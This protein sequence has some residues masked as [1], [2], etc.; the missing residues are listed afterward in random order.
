MR[1]SSR[2]HEGP[3]PVAGGAGGRRG[4]RVATAGMGR[5]SAGGCCSLPWGG[6]GADWPTG[7]LPVSRR[8]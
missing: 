2:A 1:A 6:R 5:T 7:S 8:R 3:R 4:S